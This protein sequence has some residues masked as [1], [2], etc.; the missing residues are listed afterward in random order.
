MDNQ[1][2]EI[3]SAQKTSSGGILKSFPKNRLGPKLLSIIASFIVVAFGIVSGWVLAEKVTGK[4]SQSTV[5]QS[6]TDSKVGESQ[7]QAGIEDESIFEKQA[8]EGILVRGGIDGE[9][10]HHL[11][12]PGGPSQ[13]VYLTSTVI[14][15]DSF[16]GKKVKVWGN[17]ISGVKAG[18]LMDVGKIKVIQ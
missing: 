17:T 14:D 3:L 12:R 8:P 1:Q 13:N 5:Q 7:M 6:Q 18:W 10:T 9:G 2:Q 11:E 4:K 15:L 16:V